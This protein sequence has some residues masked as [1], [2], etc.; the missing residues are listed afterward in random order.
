MLY[1]FSFV[2]TAHAAEGISVK[3]APYVL[4]EV[5]GVPIT[6]TLITSWVTMI[7]LVTLAFFVTKNVRLIPE[8]AKFF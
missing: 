3:L 7:L 6:A 8:T 4:G 2:E 1:M 5:A